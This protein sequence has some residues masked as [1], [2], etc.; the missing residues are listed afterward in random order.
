MDHRTIAL[1]EDLDLERYIPYFRQQ[2][3]DYEALLCLDAEH[4]ERLPMGPKVKLAAKLDEL[5]GSQ[6]RKEQKRPTYNDD[7]EDRPNM[8]RVVVNPADEY[9]SAESSGWNQQ[10]GLQCNTLPQPPSITCSSLPLPIPIPFPFPTPIPYL[11]PVNA[12]GGS[13]G[14]TVNL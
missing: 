4:L 8:R 1:L 13:G 12:S 10:G 6:R 7:A 5:T 11:H 3:I 14:K 9:A 2:E